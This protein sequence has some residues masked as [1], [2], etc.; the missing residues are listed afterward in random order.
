MLLSLYVENIAIIRK[1]S[2]DFDGGFTILTGETGAGKSILIDSIGLLLGN[3]SR[4][5]LIGAFGVNAVVKGLF[6]DLPK[7]AIKMLEDNDLSTSDGEILVERKIGKDGRT[8]AK[9]NGEMVPVAILQS[10]APFLINVHGQHDH[11]LMLNSAVHIEYLDR[12]AE[13]GEDLAVYRSEYQRLRE[14]RTELQNI[15]KQISEREMRLSRLAFK[16]EEYEKVQPY[17]GMLSYL[18]DKRKMLQNQQEIERLLTI[19]QP[20]EEHS[21]LM[22]V[23]DALDQLQKIVH[24]DKRFQEMFNQLSL[25]QELAASLMAEGEDLAS[26]MDRS[27]NLAEAEDRLYEL[28]Q[29]LSRYGPTEEELLIDWENTKK[30]FDQTNALDSALAEC[31][32]AYVAQ[33]EKVQRL[34]ASLSEKRLEKASQLSKLVQNELSYLD[35]KGVVFS[36]SVENNRS[37]KGGYVYN[38]RGYDKVEFL[39]STNAGQSLKPLAKIASGGELSRIMLSLTNVLYKQQ[40]GTLIFDEVDTGV[41]GKTAEKIGVKLRSASEHCQVI[42]ITHLAQIASMGDHHFKISKA[43][44]DQLT[45]TTVDELDDNQR[46]EEISRIIGGIE[47]TAS[48]RDAAREMLYKNKKS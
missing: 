8:T 31:K 25:M 42:C 23:S 13:L 5:E 46:V 24:L 27:E 16:L 40:V 28:G 47:I 10:L 22:M 44:R 6:S 4:K 2:I 37:E 20:D 38:D 36:V 33:L 32:E 34:A 7:A 3:K 9:V 15:Q 29:L 48:I 35:M 43:L 39:I 45:E 30:E 18:Q 17:V 26:E 41:S 19:I 21:L 14:C 12:F 1:V 11:I